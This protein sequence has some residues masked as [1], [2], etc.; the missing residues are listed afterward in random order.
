MSAKSD[1]YEIDVAESIDKSPKVKAERPKVSV[2]YADVK[3]MSWKGK[4]IPAN[5]PV[6]V[7]VK[8]NHTDNLGN[9]RVAWD[10]KKWTASMQPGKREPIKEFAIKYLTQSPEIKKFLKEIAEFSGIKNPKL[11]TTLGGLRDPDAVPLDVM[12]AYFKSK[13]NQYILNLKNQDLGE[14]VTN[15]YLF[16]KAE[17]AY[18]LQ[19]A[20][21]FYMIGK[22]NPL[23][24]PAS[25]P[26][27]KGTGDF[28]MRIGLRSQYYEIQPEIKIT[29]MGRSTF[30]VKP[31][32]SKKNPF[33]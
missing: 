15:H 24:L 17:P 13:P 3:I 4:T 29:D 8:M 26:K 22:E 11:P 16:G 25:I 33:A 7:E 31:G 18:Y 30:S 6:W 20:D 21:D 10:G 14:L 19:A 12:R 28:K 9:T 2:K 1:Q 32:T 5:K 27:L 23:R